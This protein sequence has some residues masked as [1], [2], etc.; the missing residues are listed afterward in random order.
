MLT[1]IKCLELKIESPK[2]EGFCIKVCKQNSHWVL[3]NRI[4]IIYG[5]LCHVSLKKP[6][7]IKAEIL[8]YIYLFLYIISLIAHLD[9]KWLLTFIM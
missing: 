5:W 7:K 3:G 4:F 1:K 2:L 8:Q 6:Q 9:V